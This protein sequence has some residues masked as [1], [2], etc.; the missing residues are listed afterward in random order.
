MFYIYDKY[1]PISSIFKYL[2]AMLLLESN[3]LELPFGVV[4]VVL[5]AGHLV[6]TSKYQ[7][8]QEMSYSYF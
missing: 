2:L 7:D 8:Y 3:Y 6:L 4:A 5:V 1:V